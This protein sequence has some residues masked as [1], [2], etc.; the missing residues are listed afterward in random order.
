VA[1]ITLR[2]SMTFARRVAVAMTLGGCMA[3]TLAASG[4]YALKEILA[5]EN[6]QR[7]DR[8]LPI[9]VNVRRVDSQAPQSGWNGI[10]DDRWHSS[11]AFR[12]SYR[13][14]F[15]DG[16]VEYLR[17]RG[18]SIGDTQEAIDI[19]VT[20][21]QFEGR[22]RIRNDGGDL[23]GGVTLLQ[24]G[25]T[26]G[27]APLFESFSYR[28]GNDERRSFGRQYT[29][30]EVSFDTVIFYRLSLSFYSAIAEA[31]LDHMPRQ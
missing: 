6:V 2:G 17:M 12:G 29:L 26:I 23:R 30:K 3:V 5:K 21:D 4:Q 15:R 19:R 27:M 20:L 16:L 22:K 8:P 7:V 9:P 14:E 10:L 13:D 31:L 24:N 18:F 1:K 11:E 28:D 25:S